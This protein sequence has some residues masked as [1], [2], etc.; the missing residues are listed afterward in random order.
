MTDRKTNAAMDLMKLAM[1]LLVVG[2]HTEPF[3]FSL[4]LDRAY[5]TVTRVCVPFFLIASSYFYW[6]RPKGPW[7]YVKRIFLLYLVWT[8]L[9][10]P[11]DLPLLREA[12]GIAGLADL[13]FW[14]GYKHLWYL[15]CSIIGFLAVYFLSRKLSTRTVLILSVL[16]FVAGC[17]KSTWAPLFSRLLH[18]E[19]RDVLGSRNGLF[20]A[21]PFMALGKLIAEQDAEGRIRGGC[22]NWIGLG[23]CFL[24]LIAESYVCVVR[25]NTEATVLWLSVLPLSYFLF[26]IVLKTEIRMDREKSLAIRRISTLVYCLHPY[27]ILPL[28]GRLRHLPLFLAVSALSVL[29]SAGIEA[30]SR[31]KAFRA[32]RILY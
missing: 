25:L 16:V 5:G 21:F 2:I 31:R 24:L 14:T 6:K 23:I 7:A 4:W 28:A 20:Y 1:A 29:I 3:G 11:S 27:L 26:A 13:F 18:T 19:I 15:V 10:L 12:G 9:Y 32:L 22:R 17:A 8:L 30:L